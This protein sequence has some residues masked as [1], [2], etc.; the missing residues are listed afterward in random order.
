[1][2]STAERLIETLRAEIAA[3]G[4]QGGV[5]TPSVYDT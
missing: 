2:S 1:M 3:L 4:Q 5:V